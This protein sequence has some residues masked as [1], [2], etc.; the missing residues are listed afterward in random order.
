MSLVIV[1]R[2]KC[3]GTRVKQAWMM[4]HWARMLAVEVMRNG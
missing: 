4:V 2:M 1:L 3:K